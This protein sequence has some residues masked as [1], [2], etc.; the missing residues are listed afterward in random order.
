MKRDAI[1]WKKAAVFY[2]VFAVV[3]AI[4]L[5]LLSVE[6][7]QIALTIIFSTAIM[8]VLVNYSSFFSRKE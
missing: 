5:A 3:S 6:P 1:D 8:A 7:R 4:V 2:G